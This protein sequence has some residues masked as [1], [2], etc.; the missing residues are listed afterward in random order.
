MLVEE[1][2]HALRPAVHERRVSSSGAILE[3]R[4]DPTS[5]ASGA[6]LDI[7]CGP[8]GGLQLQAIRR[9]TDGLS[10]W[11]VRRTD[12]TNEWMVF[13]RPAGSERDLVVLARVL[14]ATIVQRHPAGSVRVV[15]PFGVLRWEG[16]HW[17]HEAPVNTWVEGFTTS[18]VHGDPTVLEAM[19]NFAIHDLGSMGIGA[20]LIYRPDTEP[21]P[22]V[23]ERLPTP[24]PLRIQKA[25]HLAPL[26]HTLAQVD[27]AAV[28]DAEGVLRQLGVRLVPSTMAEETVEALQG[29]RHTS[30][31]RY[32]RDDPLATVIAVSDDGPVSVFRFGA[33]LEHRFSGD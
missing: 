4:S 18:S 13:D 14:E 17:H 30:G 27:G 11:L 8:V 26:R 22:S 6:Q 15:G 2:D 7:T 32:S 16:F 12:G 24:P 33:V 9:F 31:R 23:E 3:P 1:I 21:G 5:W 25:S 29:T 19:L 10:S 28:F 20:L